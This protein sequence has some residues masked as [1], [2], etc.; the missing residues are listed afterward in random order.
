MNMKS[1]TGFLE[2]FH[3][4]ENILF[5]FFAESGE[6]SEPPLFCDSL[7]V[8]DGAGFKVGPQEGNLLR[9]QR[10]ELQQDRKSTRL[11]S[12]HSQISY[13]VF[14]LKKKKKH[15]IYGQVKQKYLIGL[16]VQNW[17]RIELTW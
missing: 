17:R 9:P 10:L 4:F 6:V 7:D 11:N 16:V 13:A 12:S 15:K 1:S 5:A 3:G 8:G 14:C 2:H